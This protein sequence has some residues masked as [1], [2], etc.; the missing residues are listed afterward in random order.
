MEEKNDLVYGA[1]KIT[2]F[3]DLKEYVENEDK[4]LQ[5][6]EKANFVI[7]G[8]GVDYGK[9]YL[10]EL[11]IFTDNKEEHFEYSEGWGLEILTEKNGINKIVNAL[12]CLLSDYFCIYDRDIVEF[13]E[14]FGYEN[15]QEG[16]KIY[17]A[18]KENNEKLL[19]IFTEDEIE[20]LKDNIQL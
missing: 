13:M 5:I 10:Y 18:I 2:D 3:G 20:Y 12:W 6:L 9:G 1:Y 16:K 8:K 7:K 14:E 4:V 17:N 19:N 15:L 11:E